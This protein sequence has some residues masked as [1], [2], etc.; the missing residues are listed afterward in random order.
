MQDVS[1]RDMADALADALA[2]DAPNAWT[3]TTADELF[4]ALETDG[5]HEEWG[6]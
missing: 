1:T 2:T 6:A 5:Y 3:A 4:A